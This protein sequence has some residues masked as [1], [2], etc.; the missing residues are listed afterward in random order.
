MI[1]VIA[2]DFT[3]A[4]EIGGVGLRYGL[5]VEIQTDTSIP[6][7]VDLLIIATDT[8][9][10]SEIEAYDEVFGLTKELRKNNFEMIYKKTDSVLRG[11]VLTELKAF[12][13]ASGQ[14]NLIFNP[15]NPEFGRT[16]KGGIYYINNIPLHQTGFANDPEFPASVSNVKELLGVSN[17]NHVELASHCDDRDVTGITIGEALKTSDLD[18]WAEKALHVPVLAGAA[19]FF[20][21][22]LKVK[23]HSLLNGGKKRVDLKGKKCLYVC[24]SSIESSRNAIESARKKG[25]VVSEMPEQLINNGCNVDAE[26]KEWSSEIIDL[27]EKKSKVIM[28]INKPL[29]KEKGMP[30]KLRSYVAEATGHV[31]KNIDIDE[32]FIEGG[33]TT[34]SIIELNNFKEFIPLQVLAHGVLRMQVAG[35]R[36]LKLTI[37]PGSY[38]WPKEIWK[39]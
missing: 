12:M 19:G 31:F 29:I 38:T 6:D 10:K 9:A 23:G 1:V 13:K 11:H 26:I 14:K 17:E 22:L 20:N 37:K 34:Y 5:N 7:Y 36:N 18:C 35:E 4:A 15:A 16:I 25:A 27:I 3:G 24:G 8:R 30:Q 33:A 2:D 39:F 28:A 21:S 32:L